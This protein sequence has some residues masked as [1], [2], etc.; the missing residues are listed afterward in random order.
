MDDSQFR[1]FEIKLL[2]ASVIIGGISAIISSAL[3][4]YGVYL[5]SEAI[6]QTERLESLK[7]RPLLVNEYR[8][9]SLERWGLYTKNI[10]YGPA[11][12]KSVTI[13]YKDEGGETLWLRY[14]DGE[15]AD[16]ISL[17]DF[18]GLTG[19]NDHIRQ[20]SVQEKT[21]RAVYVNWPWLGAHY[22]PNEEFSLINF[23]DEDYT[24][25]EWQATFGETAKSR[26]R[27]LCLGI[28]YESLDGTVLS[29]L[30][31]SR[32]CAE[33]DMSDATRVN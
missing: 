30:S 24:S 33:L 15:T 27:S 6:R 28:E 3:G 1:R 18:L 32:K 12:I 17:Y 21:D 22:G 9:N 8:S 10:G 16:G 29:N 26:L 31:D 19:I 4:L 25:P 2:V 7:I 23:P 13:G 20:L 14:G 11:R 5:G